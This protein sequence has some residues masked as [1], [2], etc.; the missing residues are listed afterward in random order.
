MPRSDTTNKLAQ[1]RRIEGYDAWKDYL[2]ALR[3][4]V[5]KAMI[6][7]NS[8][9]GSRKTTILNEANRSISSEQS[10]AERMARQQGKLEGLYKAESLHKKLI[11]KLEKAVTPK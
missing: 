10:Y 1:W 2:Q 7:Q 5:N 11:E 9:R 8:I 6:A 4:L 3:L